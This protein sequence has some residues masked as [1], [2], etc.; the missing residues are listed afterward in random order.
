M[1]S[2]PRNQVDEQLDM[3]TCEL[4]SECLDKLAEGCDQ[5]VVATV[6]DGKSV[7]DTVAFD[8]DSVVECLEAAREW[9]ARNKKA[10]HY[11]IA[12]LGTVE[13]EEDGLLP[14]LLTEFGSRN[15]ASDWSG[16]TLVDGIGQ[17]DD[18]RWADPAPAGEL[19]PLFS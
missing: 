15:N 1:D 17:G 13:D 6:L 7:R 9:V 18:F 4:I 14:A 10:Q 12:Y 11:A 5:L 16:Y 3:L 19:E 8:E 2:T